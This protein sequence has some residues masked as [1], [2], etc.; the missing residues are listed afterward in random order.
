MKIG[1]LAKLSGL[2]AK[3]IRFYETQGLL[4]KA[5]RAENGYRI[6][7]QQDLASLKLI[8]RARLVGFNLDE[9][10]NLLALWQAPNRQS[11]DVKAK[12]IQKTADIEKQIAEL[13]TIHQT[14]LALAKSC[15]GNED[16]F[17]P[18]LSKL[19]E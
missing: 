5:Y 12:I 18:I 8:K 17:C 19:A 14:L 6:Y 9:C 15:P 3:T 4:P 7:Q 11:A 10:K 1:E 2:T 16:A 13:T